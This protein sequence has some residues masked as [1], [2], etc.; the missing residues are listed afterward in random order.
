[1]EISD[2]SYFKDKEKTLED[3]FI[4]SKLD[5]RRFLS[6]WQQNSTF[7]KNPMGVLPVELW[8]KGTLS[9]LKTPFSPNCMNN[10]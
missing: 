9:F 1:M 5:S 7:L 8:E 10:N 4:T 6:I 3:S 2:Q